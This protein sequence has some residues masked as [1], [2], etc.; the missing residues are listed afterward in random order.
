VKIEIGS[1]LHILLPLV[2]AFDLDILVKATSV[3]H[4]HI[5][6][7]EIPLHLLLLAR[8]FPNVAK[9]SI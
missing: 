3:A 1:L 5:P 6:R 7:P 4:F 9:K 8:Y 2:E